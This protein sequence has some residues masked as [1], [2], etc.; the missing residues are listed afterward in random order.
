MTRV[1]AAVVL[2]LLALA[3]SACSGS[4]PSTVQWPASV[5]SRVVNSC[6]QGGGTSSGCG[7]AVRYLEDH[8]DPSSFTNGKAQQAIDEATKACT[9]VAGNSGNSGNGAN[10]GN[11][12]TAEPATLLHINGSGF[13]WTP[14]FTVP[15]GD[16]G[17]LLQYIYNCA[18]IYGHSGLTTIEVQGYGSNSH[19][20]DIAADVTG[21]IGG[22]TY[23]S[24][25]TGTFA[26]NMTTDCDWTVVVKTIPPSTTPTSTTTTLVAPP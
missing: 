22:S 15:N 14:K 19:F 5:I 11:S 20:F 3:C 24:H 21:R 25:R 6:E 18:H 23:Y 2:L 16:N 1:N 9:A 7:C 12:G 10:T 26:L 8:Y 4:G 13:K 17:W